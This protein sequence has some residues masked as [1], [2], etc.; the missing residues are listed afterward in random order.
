MVKLNPNK[1]SNR[2]ALALV[3]LLVL[4]LIVALVSIVVILIKGEETKS[5]IAENNTQAVQTDIKVEEAVK[6][7]A[8]QKVE[9]KVEEKVEP[10]VKSNTVQSDNNKKYIFLPATLK[11]YDVNGNITQSTVFNWDYYNSPTDI[12]F[13]SVDSNGKGIST[14]S[15]NTRKDNKIQI[16]QKVFIDDELQEDLSGSISM[17]YFDNTSIILKHETIKLDGKKI[18]NN[19][20]VIKNQEAGGIRILELFDNLT[21]TLKKIQINPNGVIIEKIYINNELRIL[22]E[23]RNYY[24]DGVL[25]TTLSNMEYYMNNKP[26]S[27]SSYKVKSEEKV[28]EDTVIITLVRESEINGNKKIDYKTEYTLKNMYL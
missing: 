11:T 28:D 22:S 16:S 2:R 4:V 1:K 8:E 19:M 10:E 26:V 27:T 3:A 6:P 7:E 14:K 23:T 20:E 24:Y 25:I 15:T 18:T 21:N 12:Q 5:D 9:E 13:S 17:E